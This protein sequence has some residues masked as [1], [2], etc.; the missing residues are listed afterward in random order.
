MYIWCCDNLGWCQ[1]QCRNCF[2]QTYCQIVM[3][4][5]IWK[6]CCQICLNFGF[7]CPL[8]AETWFPNICCHISGYCGDSFC[9]RPL[10]WSYHFAV[11][12]F[13]LI[14]LQGTNAVF[15]FNVFV[16]CSWAATAWVSESVRVQ[17][18]Q[19]T[20]QDCD[21]LH[22]RYRHHLSLRFLLNVF[23]IILKFILQQYA[24]V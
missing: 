9:W 10:A 20:K 6:T 3:P 23:S 18:R 15:A 4:L 19:S 12:T 21:F 1:C 24:C 11:F 5:K 13:K 14:T 8:T 2:E 22:I 16:C 7:S 17:K